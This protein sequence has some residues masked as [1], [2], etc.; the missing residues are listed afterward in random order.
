MENN[1]VKTQEE[2]QREIN[3][4]NEQF[5]EFLHTKGIGAKFKL[6][7]AN[8][9][10]SARK[11]RE[12]DREN[13]EKVKAQSEAENADFV[14]LLRAKSLK[15]GIQIIIEGFKKSARE[16]SAKTAEQIAR[17]RAQTQANIARANACNPTY[18]AGAKTDYD[19]QTLAEEFN[20]FLKM[21]GLENK[22]TVVV[23]EAE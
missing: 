6:A 4:L 19:A 7:F 13:F 16:S 17:T 11:Q 18:Q 12:A 3:A 22:Y 14:A 5:K 10:E 1:N 9:G 23:N 15:E 21:K 20:E 2:M 8:M